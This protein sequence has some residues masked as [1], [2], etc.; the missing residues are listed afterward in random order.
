MLGLK[1][2]HISRR[3]PGDILLTWIIFN[4]HIDEQSHQYNVCDEFIPPL[5]FGDRLVISSHTLLGMWLLIQA[6]IK[7]TYVSENYSMVA[8]CGPKVPEV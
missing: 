8:H 7:L 3:G 1:L 4:L 5:E 2:N 6:G